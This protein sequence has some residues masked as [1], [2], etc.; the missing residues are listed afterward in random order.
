MG[1]M[2]GLAGRT[3]GSCIKKRPNMGRLLFFGS[4]RYILYEGS[5]IRNSFPCLTYTNDE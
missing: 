5:F 4:R 1:G 2:S 3:H